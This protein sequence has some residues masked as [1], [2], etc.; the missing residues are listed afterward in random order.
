M[1]NDSDWLFRKQF[2]E[3]NDQKNGKLYRSKSIWFIEDLGA[4]AK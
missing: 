1:S 3:E 4:A 2:I